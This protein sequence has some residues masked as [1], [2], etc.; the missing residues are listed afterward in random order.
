M[1]MLKALM[2]VAL[3]ATFPSLAS[4]QTTP[5]TTRTTTTTT[6]TYD[7]T[8]TTS[9]HSYA[10]STEK[11]TTVHR[12]GVGAHYL[13]SLGTIEN[14]GAIDLHRNSFALLGSYQ[15]NPSVLKAELD[16]EYIF[17]YLNSDHDMVQPSAW[18]LAGGI[19]Y[20]GAG[21]GIGHING[22][23]QDRPFYGVRLGADLPM[24][25]VDLDLFA[26]YRFQST[27]QLENILDNLDALTFGAQ[28]RF[29]LGGR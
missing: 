24:N 4:A 29:G 18:L 13:H 28:I 27:R 15:Y 26:Q 3:L 12:I 19:I 23:W 20:A 1:D 10:D 17:N 22:D 11:H 9:S 7:T 25:P 21:I 8:R 6:T 2:A 16:V 14:T 5:D